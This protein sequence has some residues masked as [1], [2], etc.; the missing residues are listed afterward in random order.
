M[1]FLVVEDLS[2]NAILFDP[3]NKE[4]GGEVL[5]IEHPIISNDGIEISNA[6]DPALKETGLEAHECNF[7]FDDLCHL[8]SFIFSDYTPLEV[9]DT[10]YNALNALSS[11]IPEG[12]FWGFSESTGADINKLGSI[13]SDELFV[14]HLV[15][16]RQCSHDDRK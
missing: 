13:L 4:L 7:E 6:L 9:V 15:R 14:V 11:H 3:L 10:L 5:A 8:L 12:L 2:V 16:I 1:S